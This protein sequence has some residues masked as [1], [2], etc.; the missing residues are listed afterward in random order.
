MKVCNQVT[1][2]EH[3]LRAKVRKHPTLANYIMSLHD[4]PLDFDDLPDGRFDTTAFISLSR[5]ELEKVALDIT[6]FFAQEDAG[7]CD[8]GDCPT[9]TEAAARAQA[10]V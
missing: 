5:E 4:A 6:T 10:E 2:C 1:S 3:A 9:C 7:E 8:C